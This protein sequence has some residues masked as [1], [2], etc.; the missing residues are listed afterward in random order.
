MKFCNS[1]CT[2][3]VVLKNRSYSGSPPAILLQP[4]SVLTTV[5][6]FSAFV[7][8]R[9][10]RLA[11]SVQLTTSLHPVLVCFALPETGT[12]LGPLCALNNRSKSDQYQSSFP[13]FVNDNKNSAAVLHVQKV[14][15]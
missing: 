14:G 5:A 8:E 2:S 7:F 10:K 1:S 9:V 11:I 13:H 12:G 6:S 15:E 4:N 3:S